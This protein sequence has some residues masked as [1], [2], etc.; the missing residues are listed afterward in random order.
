MGGRPAGFDKAIY[1]RRDE[2]ERT[3]NALKG[4]RAVATRFG[5]RA[6]L[7]QGIVTSAALHLRLRS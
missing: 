4:F 5:K 6:Y 1:K 7:F 3:L 2:V